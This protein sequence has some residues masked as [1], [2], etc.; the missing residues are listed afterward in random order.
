MF[1]IF[2]DSGAFTFF[3]KNVKVPLK[4]YHQYVN[5]N[6]E[7][8]DGFSS[9]DVIDSWEKSIKK[10][11]TLRRTKLDYVP[12]YHYGEP[13][14]V[15]EEYMQYADFVSI[16]GMVPISYQ[17]LLPWLDDLFSN[18]LCDSDGN[19]RIRV[20]GFGLTDQ[21]LMFR[22]P[23]YSVDS[24]TWIR[25]SRMGMILT[26]RIIRGDVKWNKQPT[27]IQ[28]SDKGPMKSG[29]DTH[30]DVMS[31]IQRDYVLSIIKDRGFVLGETSKEGKIIKSGICNSYKD[32]DKF[33]LL[34]MLDL[35]SKLPSWP[36]KLN[37]NK[38]ATFV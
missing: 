31:G 33:N 18:I 30:I 23:W 29:A 12:C 1:D 26:P 2:L 13:F 5:K 38:R 17:Q 36:Y 16:G 22:Y 35:E 24:S 7:Y 37:I 27:R 15:L 21:R 11:H 9:M 28:V 3:N 8:L 25:V 10:F 19:P 32:R 6:K 14:H 4:V 34:Y 20:H